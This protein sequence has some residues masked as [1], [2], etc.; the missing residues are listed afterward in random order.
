MSRP[1]GFADL[2]GRRVG[3]FGLGVEGRATV[4]R[5]RGLAAD[6]VTVD[7]DSSVGADLATRSG[8]LAALERCDVVIKGPGIPRRR[9]DVRGLEDAG[10]PVVSALDL[11]LHEV[12]RRRVIAVTGTKG[13]STTTALIDFALRCLGERAQR[14]GNIGRPPYDPTLDTSS[15]WLV[16]EVSSFQSLDLTVAPGI[17][18]VTSLGS[19]HLD[20][21]GSL[22]Q[23]HADKLHVTRTPGEHVTLIAD[24]RLRESHGDLL[25]GDVEVAEPD[26]SGLA[27]A[28]HLLGHHNDANVGLALAAAS[29]ATGRELAVV[30]TAV[31]ARASEFVPLPGRLTLVAEL[32]R[33]DYRWRFVDDG[34]ATAPLPVVAALEVVAHEPVALIVGGQDRGVDYAPL[35]RAVA[36]R[37]P[38]TTV[39]VTGQAGGR[40]GEAV[41]ALAPHVP[42]VAARDLAGAVRAGRDALPTGG[43]VLLSPGAPSFDQYENWEHRSAVF[44]MA[45]TALVDEWSLGRDSNP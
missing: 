13:K 31:R 19:D 39:L 14:L 41:R 44:A 22:A 4:A 35:A 3:V 12:D 10:V 17:V 18:V 32:D 43:V 37:R 5:L 2:A 23:Y 21:H 7:D 26:A 15:G 34:L 42:V 20:W 38:P 16:V 45:V 36:A 33:H 28:L 1:T 24:A 30:R 8:G 40:I 27:D 6:V 11:W 9:A 25:G 29:R